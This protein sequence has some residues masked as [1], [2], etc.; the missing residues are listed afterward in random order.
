MEL[1]KTQSKSLSEIEHS[2]TTFY[3]DTEELRRLHGRTV[4]TGPSI[5][6]LM[7]LGGQ[8]PV[9]IDENVD[10]DETAQLATIRKFRMPDQF[11]S[12]ASHFLVHCSLYKEFMPSLLSKAGRLKVRDGVSDG[13]QIGPLA[14]CG[15]LDARGTTE[16]PF[17]PIA[18]CA[19]IDTTDE[20]VTVGNSLNVDLAAFVLTNSTERADYLPRELQVSSITVNVFTSPGA[21]APF[22]SVRESDIGRGDPEMYYGYTIAKQLL[23]GVRGFNLYAWMKDLPFLRSRGK[24]CQ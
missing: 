21:D 11:S 2:A 7:E 10:P 13:V 9:L 12:A 1:G 17:A 6:V 18:P 16:E 14:N 3:W 8:A 24:Y 20:A 5:Q 19:P 15:R 23:N 22:G 4:P